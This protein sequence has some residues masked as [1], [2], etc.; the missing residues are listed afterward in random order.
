MK[1]LGIG[2]S[3]TITG[4]KKAA[5][6]AYRKLQNPAKTK[7]ESKASYKSAREALQTGKKFR[8]GLDFGPI[9]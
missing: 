8:I 9:L 2:I 7:R 6:K 3:Y 1:F 4:A 5:N